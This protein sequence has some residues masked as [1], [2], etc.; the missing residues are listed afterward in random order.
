M[1]CAHV[2]RRLSAKNSDADAHSEHDLRSRYLSAMMPPPALPLS[3][4]SCPV[5]LRLALLLPLPL[6]LYLLCTLYECVCVCLCVY[7]WLYL[8]RTAIPVSKKIL[9]I[10]PKTL[11]HTNSNP[12]Q[13]KVKQRQRQRRSR[14]Q[15]RETRANAARVAA[16]LS[17]KPA[18]M[19]KSRATIADHALLLILGKRCD[20]MR[21][22]VL[23]T[24][25]G[26][27]KG[28]LKKGKRRCR[29]WKS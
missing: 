19:H 27:E 5:F 23:A 4:H 7:L 8:R 18:G 22:H 9:T 14:R 16:E 15:R 3:S 11:P 6:Y 1:Q 17:W 10:S 26:P 21:T 24:I 12:K 2:L 13:S 28:P 20:A 25:P 29:H